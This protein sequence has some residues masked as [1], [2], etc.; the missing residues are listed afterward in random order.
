MGSRKGIQPV[1]MWWGAGIGYLSLARCR[2]VYGPADPTATHCLLLHEIQIGFGFTFLVLAYP[3]SP[4]QNP[5]SHK[6]V[7]VCSK[8]RGWVLPNIQHPMVAKLYV[9]PLNV[10]EVQEHARGPL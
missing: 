2:F 5:E 9:G 4:K 8:L 3:G 1:K 10:F 7:V 6:M